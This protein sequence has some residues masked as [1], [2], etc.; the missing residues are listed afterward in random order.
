MLPSDRR[1]EH[2]VLVA[3]MRRARRRHRARVALRMRL[4]HLGRAW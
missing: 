1:I 4:I 2:D 3:A